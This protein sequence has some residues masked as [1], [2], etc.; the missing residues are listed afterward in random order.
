[1]KMHFRTRVC[2]ENGLISVI[3]TKMHFYLKYQLDFLLIEIKYNLF[4]PTQID[5]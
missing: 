3:V 1:M 4:F 2:G 5:C